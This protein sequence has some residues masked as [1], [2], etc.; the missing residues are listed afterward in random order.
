MRY[1]TDSRG[2]LIHDSLEMTPAEIKRRGWLFA[3]WNSIPIWA[4]ECVRKHR[5]AYERVQHARELDERFGRDRHIRLNDPRAKRCS[6]WLEMQRRTDE[7]ARSTNSADATHN[8]DPAGHS[9]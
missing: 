8:V 7:H 9:S 6:V 2:S 4:H 3:D 5:I 1:Q